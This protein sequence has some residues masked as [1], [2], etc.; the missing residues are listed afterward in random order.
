LAELIVLPLEV[1]GEEGNLIIL[2]HER[3]LSVSFSNE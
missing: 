1:S 3:K 2:N